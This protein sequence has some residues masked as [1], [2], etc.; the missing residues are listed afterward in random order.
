M[1][2]W[3]HLSFTA[4]RCW[5]ITIQWYKSATNWHIVLRNG[6]SD[7]WHGNVSFL[8][9][10]LL[11]PLFDPCI[12][13]G[14]DHSYRQWS[15]NEGISACTIYDIRCLLNSNLPSHADKPFVQQTPTVMHDKSELKYHN[16]ISRLS[17]VQSYT[18]KHWTIN[19]NYRNSVACTEIKA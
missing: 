5:T 19:N 6:C 17:K 8:V 14:A 16:M 11:L 3:K 4:I 7:S 12:C 13:Q 10:R 2:R 9:P 1:I 15:L 18:H